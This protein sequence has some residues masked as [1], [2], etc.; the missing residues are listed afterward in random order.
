MLSDQSNLP[1]SVGTDAYMQGFATGAF[2]QLDDCLTYVPQTGDLT[3][4]GSVTTPGFA[5][6]MVGF[7]CYKFNDTLAATKDLFLRV[8]VGTGAGDYRRPGV[9]IAAGWSLDGSGNIG[10]TA[11]TAVQAVYADTSKSPG[12]DLPSLMSHGEGYFHWVYNLDVADSQYAVAIIVDRAFNNGVPT[13]EGFLFWVRDRGGGDQRQYVSATEAGSAASAPFA[14]GSG[15]F[16]TETFSRKQLWPT[17]YP[18]AISTRHSRA[19]VYRH[20]NIGELSELTGVDAVN[21]FG[22]KAGFKTIGDGLNNVAHPAGA[23][24]LAIG[25]EA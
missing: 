19:A 7:R 15:G 13:A 2:G 16:V 6:T 1:A 22:A 24:A 21:W 8:E 11:K 23:D 12:T 9:K 25:W 10:G 18:T 4:P 17:F 20:A 5:N 14:M 3:T